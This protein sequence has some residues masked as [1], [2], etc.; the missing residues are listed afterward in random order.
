[1]GGYFCGTRS[2]LHIDVLVVEG[3]PGGHMRVL[4]HPLWRRQPL[5]EF[6]AVLPDVRLSQ[7]R[8]DHLLQIGRSEAWRAERIRLVQRFCGG[9]D[10]NAT[11][12]GSRHWSQLRR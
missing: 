8:E 3:I 5:S 10:G 9:R 12:V 2:V 4:D 7:G 6:P 11:G 1:M